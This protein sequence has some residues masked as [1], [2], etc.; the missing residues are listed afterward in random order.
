M[1]DAPREVFLIDLSSILYTQYHITS[2]DPDPNVASKTTVAKVRAL[3]S[4]KPHVAICCDVGASF[5]R[6]IEARG[7][8]S[9][10]A[11]S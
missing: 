8:E 2:E 4:G 9:E 10:R 5:R 11:D 7:C 3:A 6:E 1:P